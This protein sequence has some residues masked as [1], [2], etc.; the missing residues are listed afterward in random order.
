MRGSV[1]FLQPF[2]RA[3]HAALAAVA[4]VH[5]DD[6]VTLRVT[7]APLEVVQQRP[8]EVATHVRSQ[9]ATIN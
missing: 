8:G 3:L 4:T 7:A 2:G 5:V 1:E 6:A 9:A